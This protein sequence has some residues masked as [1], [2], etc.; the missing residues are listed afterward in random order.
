MEQIRTFKLNKIYSSRNY[1]DRFISKI[2]LQLKCRNILLTIENEE[3]LGTRDNYI[4]ITPRPFQI[5]L[6]N[7][8]ISG[9]DTNFAEKWKGI[10]NGSNV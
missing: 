5:H 6:W 7:E 4:L 8:F 2:Y 10:E 3:S 1:I 9:G